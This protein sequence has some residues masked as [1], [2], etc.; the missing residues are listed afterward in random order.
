MEDH[1]LSS[2]TTEDEYKEKM[3]E[4]ESKLQPIVMKMYQAG[5]GAAV[6]AGGMP[7]MSN[8]TGGPNVEE[9]D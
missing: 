8:F 2:S 7:D 5:A 9:V 6:G 3:K 4:L 1:D